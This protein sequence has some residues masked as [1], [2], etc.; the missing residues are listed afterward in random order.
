VQ[1]KSNKMRSMPVKMPA[2]SALLSE[3]IEH[4]QRVFVLTGAGVS[5]ASGIPDYRDDDGVWK[6]QQPMQ[7]RD[8]VDRPAARQRYWARSYTGWH[9]FNQAR[10][11]TAHQALARLEQL[12]RVAHIVT[13]NV[14]GLHQRAG[15]QRVTELH[16]SLAKVVCL[17]CDAT[18][19]RASMQQ[20]LLDLNPVLADLSA[21]QAPDGDARLNDF[22]ASGINVPVCQ[23]CGGTLK[24]QVVFFGETVPDVRVQECYD[25]LSGADAML[26]VGSSLM[27]YSGF[28]FAREAHQA[29]IPIAA[30][31]RGKTRADEWLRLKI[32]QDCGTALERAVQQ[33]QPDCVNAVKSECDALPI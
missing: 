33:I 15:S 19:P 17:A 31:N 8:F 32:R 2:M 18:M 9:K 11:N 23:T 22:D 1:D 21:Q 4:H 6:N 27:L 20:N 3:F 5:T 29:G 25:A 28:R 26:V 30:V 7:Y 24:P 13:Q 12:D 14:D 10:P 16:G